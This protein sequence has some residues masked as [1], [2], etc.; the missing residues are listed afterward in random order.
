MGN[1]KTIDFISVEAVDKNIEFYKKIFIKDGILAFKNAS[2]SHKDHLKVHE[3]FGKALGSWKENNETGYTENHARTYGNHF[4]SRPGCNDILLPWHI[5]HPTYKN[6]IV[7]GT[8]NMHNFKTDSENG[9]TYFV[10]SKKLY[11][12]MPNGFKEFLKK[13]KIYDLESPDL[14][15]HDV[16]MNHWITEEPVI[17]TSFVYKLFE[18]ASA[19]TN[20]FQKLYTVDGSSPSKEDKENYFE[21][22]KWV[23][24]QLYQNTEIRLV[25]KWNQGDLL[26]S[27]I[28]LMYH[29]VTGGFE[30]SEREFVGIWGRKNREDMETI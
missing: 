10:N 26:V 30:P 12:Q 24:S 27:D 3:I 2:L 17:R 5:E 23:E 20:N 4:E 7:L 22:M 1:I 15:T 8:W 29:A 9:K 25:H 18:R 13:C 19:A 21:A 11:D 14:G 16:V 28:F 6:P